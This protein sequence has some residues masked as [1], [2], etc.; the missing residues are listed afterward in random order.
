MPEFPGLFS[1]ARRL[2]RLSLAPMVLMLAAH[3]AAARPDADDPAFLQG[4]LASILERELGLAPQAYTLDLDSGVVRVEIAQADAALQARIRAAL[5]PVVEARRLSLSITLRGR[6]AVEPIAYPPGDL[7]LPMLA[8]PKEPGFFMSWLEVDSDRTDFSMGAVG[9]GKSFGLY[10]WP[11]PDGRGGWQLEFFGAVFSQFNL[12]EHS[13]PLLNTDYQVGFPLSFRRGEISARLRLYHQSSHLGDEY[14]LSGEAPERVDLSIEA[15]EGMLARDLGRWRIYG[16]GGYLLR[17][18]PKD[19]APGY[20]EAGADYRDLR[21]RWPGGQ[22]VGGL[23]LSGW[24]E[25]DWKIAISATIGL[26]LGREL[27]QGRGSRIM[28]EYYDGP[29]PFGQF[30]TY[31]LR[32]IGV[33]WHVDL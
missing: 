19:L 9:L 20:A 7:F 12:D 1:A 10:R 33:G 15:I 24:E 32:Y 31:D 26:T 4:Y 6:D 2:G 29:A 11:D 18:S 17:R 3:A 14:L 16:G 22:L 13:Q 25:H 5:G 30:Y 28:L 8:N 21:M 23:H 27:P